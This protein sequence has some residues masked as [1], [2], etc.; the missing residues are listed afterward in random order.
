MKKKMTVFL[1]LVS[2]IACLTF[3]NILFSSNA[4]VRFIAL[5]PLAFIFASPLMAYILI[6]NNGRSITYCIIIAL[7][8]IRYVI[9]PFISW[10][11]G[12]YNDIINRINDQLLYDTCLS[13][14]AELLLVVLFCLVV[15]SSATSSFSGLKCKEIALNGSPAFY[16]IIG[17]VSL[18][19]VLS[20]GA[21]LNINFVFISAN[22]GERIDESISTLDQLLSQIANS[23]LT[24]LFLSFA[25]FCFNHYE[26]VQQKEYVVS[27]L[28]AA[29]IL[30][31]FIFGERRSSI[32]YTAFASAVVLVRLFPRYNKPIM[33][34]FLLILVIVVGLMSIYK[35]SYA[36]LY[37][38][39]IEA[40]SNSNINLYDLA[41]D[42]DMY[43]GGVGSV[44]ENYAYL[45]KLDLGLE[46]LVFDIARSTFGINVLLKNSGSTVSEIYNSFIYSGLQSTGHLITS[47]SYGSIILGPI[48]GSSAT[49]IN[50]LIAYKLEICYRRSSSVEYLYILSYVY[51]RFALGVFTSI[52]PL[53]SL[54]SRVLVINSIIIA[55]AT[56]INNRKISRKAKR[57]KTT[58]DRVTRYR[59]FAKERMLDA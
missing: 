44:A 4:G 52:P 11:S 37:N 12:Y 26:K 35:V 20:L 40:L 23:G 42:F 1:M 54:V 6:Q 39:Y 29:L 30:V 14:I 8:A 56:L 49:L 22:S 28:V 13:L 16:C 50:I 58:T 47:T 59:Q 10:Y 46:N 38:S 57:Y 3:V 2:I 9:T 19:I 33:K 41:R 25:M 27:A 31:C 18:L 36:F 43:F 45:S 17:G 21:R 32:M 24:F 48:I 51:L 15:F 7:I 55:A 5:I 53:W 34:A